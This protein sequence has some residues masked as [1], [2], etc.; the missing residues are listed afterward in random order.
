LPLRVEEVTISGSKFETNAVEDVVTLNGSRPELTSTSTGSVKFKVPSARLGGAVAITT[1]GGSSTG[2]DLFVPPT[3]TAA[4]KVGTTARMSLGASKT[5]E[6]AGS[7]KVALVLVDAT[8]GQRASLVLSESTITSGTA[9]VWSP[10]SI[11]LASASFS[12]SSGGLVETSSLPTTGTYTILLA[13]SGA[14]AGS[15]KVAAYGFQDI[16]GSITPTAT[17]EG[18]T[19][20]VAITTPGQVARYSVTMSAGE[21]VSL[22]TTNSAFNAKYHIRWLNPEGKKVV[23]EYWNAT[24][25]WFWN[26]TTF[27]GAGTYTLEVDPD[28]TG[29]GSVDLKLWED[30]RSV[31][32]LN[33]SGRSEHQ[34][35]S[36]HRPRKRRHRAPVQPGSL[37]QPGRWEV[38]QPRPGRFRRQRS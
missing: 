32:Q 14:S 27:S 31:W 34:P 25:N 9:S 30:L 26:P 3:G 23:E 33:R 1:P 21:K 5:V 19:Q 4:S 6:F 13:P 8:A 38:H 36:V 16:T 24:E 37:L 29:T 12:K 20:H 10:A 15:V 18:T 35:V 22:K 28:A 2:P 17:A 11:Q 7:E